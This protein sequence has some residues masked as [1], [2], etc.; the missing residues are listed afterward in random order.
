MSLLKKMFKGKGNLDKEFAKLKERLE[1]RDE[2]VLRSYEKSVVKTMFGLTKLYYAQDGVSVRFIVTE[3]PVP[4]GANA[5]PILGTGNTVE[6]YY[7]ILRK[8][9]IDHK[10]QKVVCICEKRVP[11]NDFTDDD[12]QAIARTALLADIELEIK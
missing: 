8:R 3:E 2:I 12:R 10:T 7:K 9:L 1:K 4:E 5:I 11:A 6:G